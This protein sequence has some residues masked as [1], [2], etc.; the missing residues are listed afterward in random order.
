MGRHGCRRLA[1]T[2]PAPAGAPA[3]PRRRM[4]RRPLAG[5][6]SEHP[7]ASAPKHTLSQK[8]AT[9]RTTFPS[10]AT[11]AGRRH[12]S[13][14]GSAAAHAPCRRSGWP[15]GRGGRRAR[16][17]R[18]AAPPPPGW[19]QR[20]RG[21][22]A[23]RRQGAFGGQAA[24]RGQGDRQQQAADHGRPA[25]NMHGPA[26]VRSQEGKGAG[27][28]R[29]ERLAPA[30]RRRTKTPAR[31]A[32]I[33]S[34]NQRLTGEEGL[35]GGVEHGEGV[36]DHG[37]GCGMGRR[38]RQWLWRERRRRRRRPVAQLGRLPRGPAGSPVCRR[39]PL[40]CSPNHAVSHDPTRAHQSW[41]RRSSRAASWRACG[42]AAGA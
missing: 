7:A 15:Q 12:K 9:A 19:R 11:Q 40:A 26:A 36:G 38:Q 32:W 1:G 2:R 31:Q 30:S 6:C 18:K 20:L 24:K 41:C 25:P 22:Q 5:A 33:S 34:S 42:R 28:A 27:E 39:R 10:T 37:R 23:R 29:G 16:R 14:Q 4:Q 13:E 3:A 35:G 8:R 21:V 17:C